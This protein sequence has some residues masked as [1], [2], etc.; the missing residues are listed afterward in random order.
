[1]LDIMPMLQDVEVDLILADLENSKDFSIL[2]SQHILIAHSGESDD[3]TE[4]K[5]GN[6]L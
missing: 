1:M 5:R 6:K 2:Q 3:D 4:H